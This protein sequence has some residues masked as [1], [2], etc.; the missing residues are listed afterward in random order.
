M[1][2]QPLAGRP[3]FAYT[4]LVGDAQQHDPFSGSGY[5]LHTLQIA[6]SEAVGKLC[7]IKPQPSVGGFGRTESGGMGRQVIPARRQISVLRFETRTPDRLKLGLETLSVRV[8]Q[9]GQLVV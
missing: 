8:W 6:F 1:G 9:G 5:N 3:I 4:A 2:V 7:N